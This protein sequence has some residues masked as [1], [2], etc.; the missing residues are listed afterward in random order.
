MKQS[1]GSRWN[2]PA[3]QTTT[4]PAIVRAFFMGAIKTVKQGGPSPAGSSPNVQQRDAWAVGRPQRAKISGQFSPIRGPQPV[5]VSPPP[6][7]SDPWQAGIGS[8]AA[9]RGLM[10][11]D[12]PFLF[13]AGAP[14]HRVNWSRRA[15]RRAIFAERGPGLRHGGFSHVS[16]K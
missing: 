11:S 16:R 14:M 12:R 9:G 15:D 8:R 10:A 13:A 5:K 6:M 4:R 3:P 7:H 1:F 2:K